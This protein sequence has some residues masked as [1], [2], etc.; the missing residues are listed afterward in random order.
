MKGTRPPHPGNGATGR[1]LSDG[2]WGTLE[3]C[4]TPEPS[5]RPT[6]EE[7]HQ[8]FRGSPLIR[9]LDLI[10]PRVVGRMAVVKQDTPKIVN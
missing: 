4:W 5:A 9:L 3:A 6:I 1:W 7:V 10:L 2:I 8:V